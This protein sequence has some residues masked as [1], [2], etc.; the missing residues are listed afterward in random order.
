MRLS[1]YI[2][3]RANFSLLVLLGQQTETWPKGHGS[4]DICAIKS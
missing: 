2:T 4:R 3:T 1:K